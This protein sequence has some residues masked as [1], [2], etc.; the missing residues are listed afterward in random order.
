MIMLISALDAVGSVGFHPYKAAVLS[1]SGS[2][3]FLDS[4]SDSDD[5]SSRQTPAREQNVV[6]R[7]SRAQ[8]VTLDSTIKVW[9]FM[10]D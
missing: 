6:R 9:D 1:A 7:S 5:E 3:H 8:P 2:R 4:D 10:G